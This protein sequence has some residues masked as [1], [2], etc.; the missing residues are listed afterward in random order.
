MNLTVP[1][2]WKVTSLN[3]AIKITKDNYILHIN[4][5]A[6]QV[7]GAKGGRFDEIAR[8]A[9]GVDLI[10]KY[11]PRFPCGVRETVHISDKLERKDLFVSSD[12]LKHKGQESLCN[13]PT[14][15]SPV[16][17]FSWVTEK[18]GGYLGSLGI[19]DSRFHE[20]NFF[21]YMTHDGRNINDLPEK[22]SEKLSVL[23]QEMTD[24]IRTLRFE[25]R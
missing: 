6:E 15:N 12:I 7:S 16:W 10:A 20:G 2:G 22:G 8:G 21:I 4:P 9:R 23:L 11:E 24:I 14:N 3:G 19:I 18:G 13:G 5:R 1:E 17:Y 25:P